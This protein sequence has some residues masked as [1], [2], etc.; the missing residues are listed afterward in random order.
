MRNPFIG[1]ILTLLKQH[2]D[3]L[4]EFELLR[5]L[6]AAYPMLDTLADEPN[7]KL[8][9]QHF[10][11]MNALYQLQRRVWQ[12][13]G[14]KLDILPTCVRI[15]ISST[16]Q[17][18]LATTS[19][20]SD[21]VEAKLADYYL[22]WRSYDETNEEDVAALLDSFFHGLDNAS[23]KQQAYKKLALTDS[24]SES[25][26]KRQYRKLVHYAHPDRG[27]SAEDFIEL[28]HAFE[29]LSKH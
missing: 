5:A 10:F 16:E 20:L 8:F 9:R 25:E 17:I 1:P 18:A 22:D 27:G 29:V 11:I 13:D 24:A 19:E 12:D 2:P 14:V 6:Q 4:S 7:L 15:E 23:E 21:S 26:I 28:R 3:G